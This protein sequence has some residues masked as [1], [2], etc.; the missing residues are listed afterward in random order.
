MPSE[1]RTRRHGGGDGDHDGDG[2]SVLA[3]DGNGP[4]GEHWELRNTQGTRT[5]YP[6][7]EADAE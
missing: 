2:L 7:A 1:K 3:E 4:R 6:T 5:G